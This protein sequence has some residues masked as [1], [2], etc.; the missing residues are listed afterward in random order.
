[1]QHLPGT[2]SL[3][4]HRTATRPRIELLAGGTELAARFEIRDVLGSGGYAVVYRAY[5]RTLQREVAL[6]ILRQDRVSPSALRRL[7]REAAVA[8][9]AV[10]PRL[11]R[12]Y[13]VEEA[14]EAVFLTMEVVE[15]GSLGQRLADGPLPVDRAVT[16]AIQALEGLEA[17]HT[18]GI[19]HRDVKPGN[20]LIGKDRELK[21]SDFGLALH[22]ERDETR[23]TTHEAVLGT[24]EYVSPEQ[25]LG[26][27][28]DARSDLYSLGVVLFEMLTGRLPFESQSSLGSLL[29]R[30]RRDA[31]PDLRTLRP[32]VP[33]W[34]AD[35]VARL[36][37][38]DPEH[39]Y[40]S[41]TAALADLRAQS[42]RRRFRPRPW[43]V[44]ALA[45]ALLLAG[46]F[47]GFREWKR[48]RFSHLVPVGST[49]LRALDAAGRTLW[50][51]ERSHRMSN[52]QTVRLADGRRVLAAFD[53]DLEVRLTQATSWLDLIDPQTGRSL[54]RV[55]L[56]SARGSFAGFSD[57]Y[58]PM[59]T[60][61]DLDGDQVDEIVATFVHSPYY[62]SY[63]VLYEPRAGRSRVVFL[64]AGHH[65]P[66][67]TVDLDGDGRQELL[68]AGIANKLG[69]ANG[70]AAV[71]ISPWL[72]ET[73]WDRRSA[74]IAR[75]PDLD[76]GMGVDGLLWYTLLPAHDRIPYGELV[77]V[78]GPRRELAL[79]IGPTTYRLDFAG[80]RLDQPS[81]LAREARSEARRLAYGGLLEG[82]RLLTA[83]QA[84][85]AATAL[86]SA[87]AQAVR[88]A[89]PVLADWCQQRRAFALVRAG[90]LAQGRELF[91]ELWSRVS[92]PSEVAFG[93][94]QALHGI[95]RLDEAVAWYR[96]ALSFRAASAS[97]RSKGEVLDMLLLALLE[98]GRRDEAM[99]EIDRFIAIHPASDA[100]A[101]RAW[102]D[103]YFGGTPDPAPLTPAD[104][105]HD[106]YRYLRLEV[107]L[108][109]G[110]P[111]DRLLG[112]VAAARVAASETVP[113]LDGLEAELLSRLGRDAAAL[114]LARRAL[115][116][117]RLRAP[118]Q[119]V[120][121]AFLAQLE[122]RQR[123][124]ERGATRETP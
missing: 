2:E 47:W 44:A 45:A 109:H 49:G 46:G 95:G 97:G 16:W 88:A 26:A 1:M 87:Q 54:E 9:D 103:W 39:R 98:L 80:F 34:L 30:L 21:L 123:R 119:V 113:L 111:P 70:L 105:M 65:R 51:R 63:N 29:E 33:A 106:L 96:R 84:A 13:D 18:L 62:P 5:D 4:E 7:R 83:G 71:R 58:T 74:A 112:E 93:A 19:L 118:D 6:K 61:F 67:G 90:Q 120:F 42:A 11:V 8:R 78:D 14:A 64:S 17:L 121:R 32:N 73:T 40:P 114:P 100:I 55:L 72:S 43:L 79:D 27:P 108:R 48:S 101:P 86:E 75:T 91:E 92:A 38:R 66:V 60:V 25:A 22:L 69:W 81:V 104:Q 110:A 36:L 68:F 94:A 122:E 24:L 41:A 37:E 31:L 12:I 117:A 77:R 89:E 107:D 50:G 52:F 124:I 3:S 28:T 10:H 53:G 23:A 116:E 115:S 59:L 15:G 56:P 102:V 82:Q 57:T 99:R 35:V 20:L 85:L 76:L